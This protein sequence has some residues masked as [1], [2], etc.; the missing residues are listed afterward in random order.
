MWRQCTDLIKVWL[1]SYCTWNK[2]CYKYML[3]TLTYEL[4]STL[5]TGCERAITRKETISILLLWNFHFCVTTFFYRLHMNIYFSVDAIFKCLY[6]LL[7]SPWYRIAANKETAELNVLS[8]KRWSHHVEGRHHDFINRYEISVKEITTDMFHL[9][10]A[11]CVL[12]YRSC[13]TYY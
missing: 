8:L 7:A 6:F 2:G 12:F 13:M 3:H 10:L 5:C 11:N 9:S 1:L 4:T